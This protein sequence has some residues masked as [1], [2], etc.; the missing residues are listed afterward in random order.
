MK[1]QNKNKKRKK[2]EKRE[3]ILIDCRLVHNSKEFKQTCK[4]HNTKHYIKTVHT[5]Q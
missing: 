2:K 5:Q 1:E 4:T 3:K